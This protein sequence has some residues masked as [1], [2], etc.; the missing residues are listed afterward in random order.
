MSKPTFEID[1]SDE[2]PLDPN[3]PLIPDEFRLVRLEPRAPEPESRHRDC[4]EREES[5]EVGR[6]SCGHNIYRYRLTIYL[7]CSYGAM[8]TINSTHVC[9]HYRRG[10]LH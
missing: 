2:E 9:Q 4:D 8:D 7:A 1:D 3:A 5:L 10:L 6:L